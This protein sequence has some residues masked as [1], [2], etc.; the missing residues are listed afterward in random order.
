MKIAQSPLS[1]LRALSGDWLIFTLGLREIS[2]LQFTRPEDLY[3]PT[4]PENIVLAV[5][6]KSML[7]A[8]KQMILTI[9]GRP[10]PFSK[11]LKMGN[12]RSKDKSGTK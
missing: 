3:S 6:L 2:S 4:L 5:L 12:A 8:S 9:K 11:T 1:A 7:D 10:L